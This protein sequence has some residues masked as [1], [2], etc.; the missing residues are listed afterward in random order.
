LAASFTQLTESQKVRQLA[1]LYDSFSIAQQKLN[2]LG[3]LSDLYQRS[4]D[5]LKRKYELGDTTKLASMRERSKYA[6][7]DHQMNILSTQVENLRIAIDQL[8]LPEESIVVNGRKPVALEIDKVSMENNPSL[9]M[10]QQ[11]VKASA[12]KENALKNEYLPGIYGSYAIT[13]RNDIDR[14]LQVFQI[15]LKIPLLFFGDV[16]RGTI[17]AGPFAQENRGAKL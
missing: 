17:T 1:L 3:T 12:E 5:R 13:E 15:G 9:Q 16:R 11:Q 10:F 8:V 14:N 7:I 2:Y 4:A 6:S